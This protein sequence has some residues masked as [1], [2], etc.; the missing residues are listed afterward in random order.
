MSIELQTTQV[1]M[2]YISEWDPREAAHTKGG[3]L[4]GQIKVPDF[5]GAMTM[6]IQTYPAADA[7]PLIS[8]VHPILLHV[9]R[10][11]KGKRDQELEPVP[12]YFHWKQVFEIKDGNVSIMNRLSELD[13]ERDGQTRNVPLKDVVTRMDAN[14]ITLGRKR[15]QLN[16]VLL[17]PKQKSRAQKAEATVTKVLM[18]RLK[19]N[20][21]EVIAKYEKLYKGKNSKNLKRLRL[22]VDFYTDTFQYSVISPQTIVDSGNKDIGAMDFVDAHPRKS[23]TNGNRL[24]IIISEYNLSKDITPIFQIF[25]TDSISGEKQRPDLEQF[26]VQ[27]EENENRIE[28]RNTQI[29]FRTPRQPMLQ[30][31]REEYTLKLAVRRNGD[32]YISSTKFNFEYEQHVS[33]NCLECDW[34]IDFL[35]PGQGMAE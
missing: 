8:S 3:Y 31:I 10:I 15:G 21:E 35:K 34:D 24:I 12:T 20:D 6:V 25:T 9:V 29:T 17:Q 4:E 5:N 7:D 13:I 22:K 32:G 27:P 26:L 11:G 2:R 1:L 33:G 28:I 23:C 14:T 18:D 19:T 30:R 16:L